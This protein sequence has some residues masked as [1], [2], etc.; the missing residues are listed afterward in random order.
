MMYTLRA[1]T[2]GRYHITVAGAA[3]G[4]QIGA[5]YLMKVFDFVMVLS[6]T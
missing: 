3:V 4:A 2:A 5:M 1:I 6:H